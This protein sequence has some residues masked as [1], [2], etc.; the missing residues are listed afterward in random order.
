MFQKAIEDCTKLIKIDKTC[1]GAYYIRGCAFEKLSKL[2][3]A[4]KDLR[5]A[6]KYDPNHVSASFSLASCENK[7][8][9]YDIANE[10]Y[11]KALETDLLSKKNNEDGTFYRYKLDIQS[12]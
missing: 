5:T 11:L 8:G 12:P 6:L 2:D 1:S 4:V 3:Q 7:R 9:N 10:A